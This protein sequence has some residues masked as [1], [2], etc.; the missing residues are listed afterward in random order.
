MTNHIH[1][2]ARAEEGH[3]LSDILRD[4]KK[5]TCKAVLKAI[6]EN[7]RE[8][9]KEWLSKQFE[10]SEGNR[11]WR[12]DNQPIELLSDAVIAQKLDYI[13]QNPVEEDWFFV[14]KIM[15]IAVPQ[16]MQEEKDYWIYL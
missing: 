9:R 12:A 3:L 13:H 4:F 14:P 10:T 1:L 5:F 15:F 8:S 7:P 16:I 11:F 6:T 2:I